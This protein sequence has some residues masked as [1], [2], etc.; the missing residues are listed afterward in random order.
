[1]RLGK[2]HL[3]PPC[4]PTRFRTVANRSVASRSVAN[5]SSNAIV[6]ALG[7]AQ[8]NILGRLNAFPRIPVDEGDLTLVGIIT[9]IVLAIATLVA[10]M[11]GGL[12]GTRY[13]RRV[14]AAGLDR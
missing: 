9:A 13:H 12:T 3:P 2:I 10:A 14:D 6:S 11:L 1:M 8:F 5:G 4:R 7:G